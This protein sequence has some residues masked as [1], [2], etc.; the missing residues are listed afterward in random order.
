VA[1]AHPGDAVGHA[2]GPGFGLGH[3]DV[4]Q[5]GVG[6]QAVRDEPAARRPAA[7]GEV[8]QHDAAVVLLQQRNGQ[9]RRS[10]GD[11]TVMGETPT[12][13]LGFVREVSEPKALNV[14]S[15]LSEVLQLYSAKLC[16]G[17]IEVQ[18]DFCEQC[19][20]RGF[21]GELR[22]LFAN[23]IVNAA[24]AMPRGGRLRLR[25][26]PGREYAG[27][28]RRGV[29]VTLA[30]TGTGITPE[31]QTRLF[32]PFY[33]TKKESGTGLGLWLS[34]GIIR[35]HR[36]RIRVRSCARP[37]HSGTTFSLFLPESA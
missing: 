7:A 8:V 34:E 31:H 23:L 6:E 15:T 13:S 11:E 28:G 36:G 24:D 29:R 33:T 4:G 17:H 3:A 20:I 12:V 21:A 16:T 27:E 22:Q 26:C 14:S 18:K 25:V 32:E 2:L 30:D 35:K 10:P 1:G 37:G 19:E 5:L 9:P